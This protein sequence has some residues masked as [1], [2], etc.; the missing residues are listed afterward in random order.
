[1]MDFSLIT[2]KA[3]ILEALNGLMAIESVKDEPQ[4]NM[5]YGK[6]VFDA[7]LYMLNLSEKLD[8]DSVNLF[9]HLGYVEYGE[10]DEQFAILTHL[11]V[12]PAGENWTVKP[13]ACTVKDGR[14]YGRGAVDNKGP[15]VAALFALYAIKENCKSL[16]KKVRLIFGCDE[17]SGWS[18]MKFYREMEPAEPIYAISP[19]ADFPIINAEKGLLHLAI[20]KP[21]GE[22]QPGGIAL[23]SIKSGTRVNVVPNFAECV[24]RGQPDSIV[25]A[26]SLY[27]SASKYP[28]KAEKKGDDTILSSYGLAA[29]GSKPQ[30]GYN[31]LAY[32]ISFLNTLPL[33][34]SSMTDLVYAVGSHINTDC[35]GERLQIACEDFSGKLTLNLGAMKM[36]N[37]MLSALVDIRYPVHADRAFI[38]DKITK[39]FSGC[40]IDEMH[41]MPPHYVNE[42]SEFIQKLKESYE[43]IMQE[44][45]ECISIGGA[46]YARVFKNSVAFGPT[47]PGEEGTEHQPDESISI[48]SLIRSGDIIANAILRL[49]T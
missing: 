24:L 28:F 47:F 42:D 41:T 32:L 36:E 5:P 27:N 23:V 44:K 16:N 7:L 9:S 38:L 39:A 29:H 3:Q 31:A 30:N 46:T 17:E 19:D 11:D 43:E 49:C 37:G 35:F 6:G 14:I 45:A 15:A 18:D 26:V 33:H 48:E 20:R 34:K 13:F 1:M 22:I 12:V 10:G 2:Y 21:M 25:K 4:V 8:F 40:T